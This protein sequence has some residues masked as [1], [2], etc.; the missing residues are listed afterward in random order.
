MAQKGAAELTFRGR[1]ERKAVFPPW[2]KAFA[3][4]QLRT[5]R[6]TAFFVY[7]VAGHVR[8][9]KTVFFVGAWVHIAPASA[10]ITSKVRA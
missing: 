5:A 4:R 8:P 2:G 1:R 6:A 3:F 7:G 10:G 9:Q